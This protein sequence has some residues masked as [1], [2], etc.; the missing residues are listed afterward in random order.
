[1]EKQEAIKR[2]QNLFSWSELYSVNQNWDS[3]NKCENQII[4]FKQKHNL[5]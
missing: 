3:Y 4:E 2:L 5:I 1:M